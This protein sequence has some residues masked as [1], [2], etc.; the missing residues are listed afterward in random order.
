MRSRRRICVHPREDSSICRIIPCTRRV[1]RLSSSIS[2][3]ILRRRRMKRLRASARSS[4]G[5]AA[6]QQAVEVPLVL[7]AQVR[8]RAAGCAACGPRSAP[9]SAARSSETL[10]VRSKGSMPLWT[11][12]SVASVFR[13]ARLQPITVRRNRLRVTS[14][15]LA[16]AISSSRL[17]SGI[18]A[19]CERYMRIGSL[20]HLATSAG[21]GGGSA[22]R[23]AVSPSASRRPAAS[24]GVRLLGNVVELAGRRLVHQIDA[25]LLQ[26]DQQIVELVGIDFLVGQ[27]FVDLV[28]GQI[29]LCLA[30]GDQFL[31]I[32]VEK[33]HLTTPLRLLALG[34]VI[35]D[36][37][38]PGL[39]CGVR[40]RRCVREHLAMP[41]RDRPVARYPYP[42]VGSE[43]P[44]RLRSCW[45]IFASRSS[46][47][48]VVQLS[49]AERDVLRGALASPPPFVAMFSK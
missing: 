24:S 3:S 46:P 36:Q 19:I 2:V 44:C 15:F 17:K 14:I 20:L 39:H 49:F 37:A 34:V 45:M 28:V 21:G 9:W 42:S 31:Q 35:C 13:M 26:G 16:R 25:L 23:R 27:I 40:R 11:L 10:I 47:G 5:G 43:I 22:R 8:E 32:L 48:C 18:S 1:R 12:A 30:L 4:A 33:V 29:S 38:A 41:R 7:L 6:V